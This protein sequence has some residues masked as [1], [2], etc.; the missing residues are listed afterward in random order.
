[1]PINAE[2][3]LNKI[4]NDSPVSQ[5]QEDS[6]NSSEIPMEEIQITKEDLATS[7]EDDEKDIESV[8]NESVDNLKSEFSHKEY[9]EQI[10]Y[11]RA[12]LD[13]EKLLMQKRNEAVKK[14]LEE[15]INIQEVKHNRKQATLK[16]EIARLKE[17]QK[18]MSPKPK[19]ISDDEFQLI[20]N[21]RKKRE[22]LL[23]TEMERKLQ[24]AQEEHQVLLDKMKEDENK[25]INELLAKIEEKFS[26]STSRRIESKRIRVYDQ[27]N[28]R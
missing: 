13:K 8:G 28:G 25:K 22:L 15:K 24:Q 6:D 1:M 21:E 9:T 19:G 26:A 17:S 23:Q 4:E 11:H 7:S 16:A 14:Q 10:E 12:T 5:L 2:N 20:E 3:K 27:A 18:K